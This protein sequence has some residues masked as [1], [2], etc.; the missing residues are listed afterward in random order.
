MATFPSIEPSYAVRKDQSPKTKIVKFADGYEQRI[1]FGTPSHQNPRTYSLNWENITDDEGNTIDYF[2]K[3]RA[4]D[5]ASFD[6]VPPRESFVKTGTYAQSSNDIS[7]TITDHRLFVG[8][9]VTIDFQTGNSTD[10]VFIVASITNPNVF[11]VK[12]ANNL[13]TNGDVS[14]TKTGSGKFVCENWQITYKLP[15][16][17]DVNATFREVFEP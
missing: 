13:T 1:I 16:L 5:K 7:I 11:V 15:L 14:V 4:N 3:E 8:D 9:S 10:G 12:A 17:A 2:L 6:Y